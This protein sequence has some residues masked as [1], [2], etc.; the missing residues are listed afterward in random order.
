LKISTRIYRVNK[1]FRV[2]TA[3]SVRMVV[4]TKLPK[5]A[6]DFES[7]NSEEL[8]PPSKS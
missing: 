6:I 8:K 1:V 7:E 5:I 4:L 3:W 2:A